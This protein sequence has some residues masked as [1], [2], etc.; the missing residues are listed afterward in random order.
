MRALVFVHGYL[1]GGA[2]WADQVETFSPLF[3]VITPDLPGYGKNNAIQAPNTIGGFADHVLQQVR[4]MGVDRFD[5]VG[6]SMGGMIVQEMVAR[7]PERVDRLVLYGTGPVGL[8]PGRFETIDE[9]KRRV[10]EDGAEATGRRI[11]ATWF[12]DCER[13]P[14]YPVCAEL[15]V[16]ASQ[17]AA[18][19]GLSAMEK[20]SGEAA[21][22]HIVSPTLVLWGDCDR[23]YMWSQQ[24]RLWQGI[25]GARLAVIPGCAHAVHLEKPALFNSMLK[26]FL[27][28]ENNS[29]IRR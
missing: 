9:S 17:Q 18:L 3:R 6:H 22:E 11:S 15:A 5:L 24:Q 26:D 16:M 23:T 4:D 8:L 2:Q 25:E 19:A 14:N 10:V 29:R 28:P 27:G 12:V 7:A 21:L 1:G 20:W 13:A